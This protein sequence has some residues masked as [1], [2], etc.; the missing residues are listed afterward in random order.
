MV[1]SPAEFSLTKNIQWS[2]KVPNL[3]SKNMQW[4]W[5][6]VWKL[7]LR[8][9]KY[10]FCTHFRSKFDMNFLDKSLKLNT[11]KCL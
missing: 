8:P 1:K 6:E 5:Y 11:S 10:G 3:T 4:H 9:L 2:H 7:E